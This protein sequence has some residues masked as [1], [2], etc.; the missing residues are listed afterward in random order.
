ML[1]HDSFSDAQRADEAHAR[2]RALLYERLRGR[3]TPLLV[4]GRSIT[5]GASLWSTARLWVKR[6]RQLGL[7]PGDRVVLALPSGQAFLAAMVAG[8]WERIA[9]VP[10]AP[11]SCPQNVIEQCGARM[12]IAEFPAR[13]PLASCTIVATDAGAP[14]DGQIHAR[15][16]GQV[17]EDVALVMSTSGSSG[18][19]K[20]VAISFDALLAQV[21]A[22]GEA[23]GTT[24]DDV[25]FSVLPWHHAFGLVVDLLP[26]LLAGATIVADTALAADGRGLCDAARDYGATRMSAV[27]QTI[28]LV[29]AVD[30]GMQVLRSLRGGVVGGARVSA[31]VAAILG[32][33]RLRAGYGL[34]E[35]G[36][37]VTLGAP[38]VWTAGAMGAPVGC[39]VR[40]AADGAL[41]VRGVG[42]SAGSFERGR[43]ERR[44]RGSWLATGDVVASTSDGLAFMGRA[45]HRFKL[46]NGRMVDVPRLERAI[47][48]RVGGEA[49]VLSRDTRTID[50]LVV[51]S[52]DR[53]EPGASDGV[54]EDVAEVL[55]GLAKRLGDVRLIGRLDRTAK[56]ECIR[57]S[58]ARDPMAIAA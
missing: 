13:G 58:I 52:G 9:L 55:G 50:V 57:A 32:Q 22:H 54:R 18:A 8:L 2:L 14:A 24:S 28:R 25:C 43:L 15:V 1:E 4:A 48:A 21:E 7:A 20:R 42:T 12:V 17:C 6:F 35:A 53:D 41:H 46:E 11:G 45:D 29:S 49:L 23:L 36:P 26:S 37:G 39:E 16:R 38:G 34:T 40:I 10:I 30:G 5:P 3:P 56:G 47:E 19:P 33:T 27:P 31:D 44:D 51:G